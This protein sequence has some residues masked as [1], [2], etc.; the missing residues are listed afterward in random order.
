MRRR[1]LRRTKSRIELPGGEKKRKILSSSTYERKDHPPMISHDTLQT[2]GSQDS[3]RQARIIEE[4]SELLLQACGFCEE[5]SPDQWLQ[6]EQNE[7]TPHRGRGRPQR[8]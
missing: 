2:E 8:V 7:P 1:P 3:A 4:T 6:A 5:A